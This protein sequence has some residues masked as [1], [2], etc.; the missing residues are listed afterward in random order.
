MYTIGACPCC[1]SVELSARWAVVSPFLAEYAVGRAPWLCR[2]MDCTACSFRF[3]D[4]R[5]TGEEVGRLYS[6][7]RG[8]GYFKARHR[9]EFWYSHKVN[10]GIGGD[11]AEIAARV[12]ALEEVLAPAVAGREIDSVLDYGGDRGQFMPPTVGRRRFVFELSDAEPVAGVTRIASE[13][14]L[15][16]MTFDLIL[17]LGVLE[18]CSEPGDVLKHL[19]TRMQ[20]GS[21]IC[22][23]VPYER[24]DVTFAGRGRLYRAWLKM[25]LRVR[26]ALIAVDFYATAARVRLN[27]IPPLGLVKCHEHLNFFNERSMAALLERT[28]FAVMESTL[29]RTN[30]YPV[31]TES[32]YVVARAV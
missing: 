16:G 15:D 20:A 25:L 30:R 22:V 7:Y 2:L 31:R 1:G 21:L 8:E 11:P 29:K 27:W 17:A 28:G 9:A 24:Y 13:L 6:G 3:F 19:R 32:M 5:L 4:A 26:P 23:G 12:G 10:D 14:E 18:H